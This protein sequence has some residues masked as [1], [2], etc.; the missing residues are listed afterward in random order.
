MSP[1]FVKGQSKSLFRIVV[2]VVLVAGGV[3]LAALA[4]ER[5]LPK[6]LAVVEPKVLYRSGQ[7][8]TDQLEN[9]KNEYGIRTILI[10][11]KGDSRRVPEEVEYAKA[12]GMNVVRIPIDSRV[13]ISD[14]QVRQFFACV[15]DPSNRPVLIHCSAG[16]HRTGYLCALYRIERQ[17]WT[18]DQAMDEMISFGFDRESQTVV[19]QQ[20][21]DYQPGQGQFRSG[22]Q[23]ASDTPVSTHP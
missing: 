16:R 19:E 8:D 23:P 4:I 11:R 20:L 15:D 1:R 2:A 9:L 18:V 10:V 21:R 12:L 6:R 22:G 13:P 5:R 14:D 3:G 7:P 17:G